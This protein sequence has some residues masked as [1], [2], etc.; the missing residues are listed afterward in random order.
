VATERRSG[1]R[2]GIAYDLGCHTASLR[3]ALSGVDVLVAESNHD[4]GMLRAGPYPPVLQRRIS[5]A[6][7]HLSNDDGAELIASVAHRG[8][9]QV[10]LAHLSEINNDPA[11]ALATTRARLGR[12]SARISAAAQDAVLE[13]AAPTRVS[14]Q[15]QL[16]LQL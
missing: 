6:R 9:R 2:L 7:G 5:S 8:L 1:E 3:A 12:T 11:I 13:V 10:V 16:Q 14:V 4:A 15:L